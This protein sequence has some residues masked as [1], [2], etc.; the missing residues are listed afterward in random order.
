MKMGRCE[1]GMYPAGEPFECYR[2]D[3]VH[4]PGDPDY[5]SSGDAR[6]DAEIA[7]YCK[8]VRDQNRRVRRSFYGGLWVGFILQ[9]VLVMLILFLRLQ[10]RGPVMF[11]NE[12]PK[13]LE[14]VMVKADG[15]DL[16]FEHLGP[17]VVWHGRTP[18]GEVWIEAQGRKFGHMERAIDPAVNRQVIGAAR[19]AGLRVGRVID[20]AGSVEEVR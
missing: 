7:E 9:G 17:V 4:R 14:P 16:V 11:V 3:T 13:P 5:P 8:S 20:Q 6:L 2:C 19:L 10:V 15:I 18:A 1:G 12:V